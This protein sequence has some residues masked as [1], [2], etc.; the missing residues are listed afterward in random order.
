MVGSPQL[1][2][3]FVLQG[4]STIYGH[5]DFVLQDN[6]KGISQIQGSIPNAR[7]GNTMTALDFNQ[8]GYD[9]LVVSIPGTAARKLT[10]KGIIEIYFGSSNGNFQ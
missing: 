10:Y 2:A 1:G 5:Q 9:D 8:D 6:T 3:A 7:F 4:G